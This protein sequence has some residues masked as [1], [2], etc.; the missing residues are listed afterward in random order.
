MP[1][2]FLIFLIGTSFF[3]TNTANCQRVDTAIFYYKYH[4]FN[5]K[6]VST[7]DSA[8]YFRMILPP[9]AGDVLYNIR[10]FYADGKLKFMGKSNP[11][12]N[13]YIDG[14][15]VLQ[16]D[17]I[18]FFP[19]GHHSSVAR[20][21]KG[22]HVGVNYEYFPNGKIYCI[23]KY[24]IQNLNDG[25]TFTDCY[26]TTGT[27]IC[28][29]GNGQWILYDSNFKEISIK[30][31][32]K[33]GKMEGTWFGNSLFFKSIKFTYQF[34]K[35]VFISGIGYDS[36]GKAYPFQADEKLLSYQYTPFQFAR[37]IRRRFKIPKGSE[38]KL[39]IDTAKVSFIIETDGCP[40]GIKI[41]DNNDPDI[42]NA[43]TKAFAETEPWD[44]YRYYGI[45][46]RTQVVME[47]KPHIDNPISYKR[48]I[49]YGYKLLGF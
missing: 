12:T 19:N 11:R 18:G 42:L 1:K 30:G 21:N 13:L 2:Y 40:S 38:N 7:L 46:M 24:D 5:D 34:K 6:E 45:P 4:L 31:Q 43:I 22:Y 23:N 14:K 37:I 48:I 9:D 36:V 10:E 8:D 47:L 33:D 32:I 25:S 20:Y 41:L 15:P 35:G 3:I 44:P 29:D 49:N 39:S 28:K 16:G 17:A 26:D 27:A